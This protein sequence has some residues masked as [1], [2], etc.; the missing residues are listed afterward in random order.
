MLFASGV[1]SKS[2]RPISRNVRL[3]ADISNGLPGGPS[4]CEQSDEFCSRTSVA[5]SGAEMELAANRCEVVSR[6]PNG[7]AP[8]QVFCARPSQK[9]RLL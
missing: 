4:A 1:S 8:L 5:V 7:F 3:A 6:S 2:F 9:L